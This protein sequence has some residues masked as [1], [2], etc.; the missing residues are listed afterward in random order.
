MGAPAASGRGII[1]T[2]ARSGGGTPA[3]EALESANVRFTSHP[4]QLTGTADTYGE[5]VAAVLG[6]DPER[7]FKTL[8]ADIDDRPAVAIVPVSARLS[9]KALARVGGGRKA[10]M[11][12]PVVAERL[13][14]YVTGGISPFGQKRRLPTFVDETIELFDTIY[15]S[16]GRRGLQLEVAPGDLVSLLD[17]VVTD[18]TG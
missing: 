8:L 15:V 18:L 7:L 5:A 4:Y 14:G 16:G 12:S 17:A 9:M 10:D 1:A 11:M 6:V 3:V 2:M 13:T